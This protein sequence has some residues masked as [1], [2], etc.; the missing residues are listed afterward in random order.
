MTKD[1]TVGAAASSIYLGVAKSS[2]GLPI[3]EIIVDRPFLFFVRDIELNAI[4]FAG[5][6]TN[7]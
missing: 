5:K 1:G 7:P 4:V 3:P 6:V 2:G